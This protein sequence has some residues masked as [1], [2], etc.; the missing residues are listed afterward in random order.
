[1]R[2]RLPRLGTLRTSTPAAAEVHPRVLVRRVLF[3]R[4]DDVVARLPREPLGDEADAVR[5]VRDEADVVGVGALMSRAARAAD[6]G[7]AVEPVAS[8]P[9]CR[10]RRGCR[11]SRAGRRRRRRE[12]G[13]GGVVEER[14]PGGDRELRRGTLNQSM[15]CIEPMS[16]GDCDSPAPAHTIQN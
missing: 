15:G 9:R 1:M 11:R 12:R 8:R 2:T 3:G 6:L 10:C 7:D 14:P 13:D 5:G 4:E 16:R